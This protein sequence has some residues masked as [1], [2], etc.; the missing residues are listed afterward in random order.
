[1][2]LRHSPVRE[3]VN[4]RTSILDEPKI[5]DEWVVA[6]PQ[7]K[8]QPHIN[9]RMRSVSSPPMK[10]QHLKSVSP[11]KLPRGDSLVTVKY[12][13]IKT[14]LEKNNQEAAQQF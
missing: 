9:E 4:K 13:A 1:M 11:D 10:S 2:G 5:D 8:N 12:E 3:R 7:Q 6:T 14:E